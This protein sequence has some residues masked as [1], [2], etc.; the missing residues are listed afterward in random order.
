MAINWKEG[1][2]GMNRED[3]CRRKENRISAIRRFLLF[4]LL[5]LVLSPGILL[6]DET[7]E[8]F[9]YGEPT[10]ELTQQENEW[11]RQHPVITLSV[12]DGYPPRNFL[13]PKGQLVG[14]SI[15]YIDLLAK[16]LGISIRYE[17]SPWHEALD[18]ALRHEVHGVIN[19]DML[20]DRKPYLDF[21]D[22]Y[23]VYPQALV[24]REDAAPCKS[25]DEFSGKKVAVA[26]GSSALALI[27]NN[28]P[29]VE[30]LEVNNAW[31]GIQLV[32]EG[33]AD[34]AFD[35]LA[36]LNYFI[37]MSCP[38]D[39][40][41]ALVSYEEPVGYSR[42]GLRNDRP[43][44]LSVFN[45]A[46]ASLSP[47]DHQEIQ[48]RW[49]G[50]RVPLVA[51]LDPDLA[52]SEEERTWVKEHPVVR[53]YSDPRW[54]PIEFFDEKGEL[55]GIVADFLKTVRQRTGIQFKT[56]KNLGWLEALEQVGQK[57][58]DMFSCISKT[59]SRSQFLDFTC[60][61][62]KVPVAIYTLDNIPY[63]NYLEQLNG[64]KVIV[65]RD[66]YIQE[67]LQQNHP[68]ID[69]VLI[70]E[71]QAAFD[72]LNGRE[73][74]A[75]I[76]ATLPCS[77]Y[78]TKLG[79]TNIKING[80]TPFYYNPSMGVR[81]DWPIFTGSLQKALDSINETERDAIRQKWI[82]IKY[83]HA[84]DYTLLWKIV[85]F[86]LLALSL[87]SFWN[88]RL[89]H[90]I[91][92]RKRAESALQKAH[93]E[94][95]ARVEE[96]TAEIVKANREL[97]DEIEERKLAE[98]ALRESEEK[99]RLLVEYANDAIFVVQDE[100]ILFPNPKAVGLFGCSAEE[101]ACTSFTNF[102]HPQD[103]TFVLDRYRKG[104]SGEGF[105]GAY[106]F[107]ISNQNGQV[108]SVQ[109]SAVLI[110]W[111]GKPA[112]LSFLRDV[113]EQR[114]LETQLRQAQ[115]MEAIGTL[116][117]G[118]AHDFNNILTSIIGFAEILFLFKIEKN[119]PE[120]HDLEQILKAAHR[121]KDLV[122][123]ILT[124]GRRT[125]Q[126]MKPI[127]LEPIIT[128]AVRFLKAVLPTTI[129]IR[130]FVRCKAARI[131]AD[132]TQM[133]QVVMN[134]CTNAAHAMREKGGV[135]EIELQ[136]VELDSA[137][138]EKFLY[139]APGPYVRLTLTDTGHGMAG[140]VMERIFDP[141]FTT[142]EQG[143]G[144]GLGL[145]VVH[146]IVK[147][148]GG[149]IT[150]ESEV[151]KGSTFDVL[152][153]R[154]IGEA[155]TSAGEV[156]DFISG[157]NERILFI[158]DEESIVEMAKSA[159]ENL[160]YEVIGVTNSIE[161]LETFQ[162]QPDRN[163]LVI[164]DLTMPH[165]TGLELAEK[166]MLVKPDIPIILFSGFGEESIQQDAQTKG[167]REFL[168]KPI[169][170]LALTKTIRKVLDQGQIE[171]VRLT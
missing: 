57:K 42:I 141:Y 151:G 70:E 88:R 100:S 158:D 63:I 26:K 119:R 17:G 12:D 92:E 54:M 15:D 103:R 21:T 106:S 43:E 152:L 107:R 93:D 163:H 150:V 165:M 5:S 29:A 68:K 72:L 104:L 162:S 16:R 2:P 166:L 18:K 133:L 75:F 118:I 58:I 126:E 125:E 71:F 108:L 102:I 124:F 140:E 160:G 161:A 24:T 20:Q 139:L 148:H 79:F 38:S 36:V 168:S 37:S 113:T 101:L 120:R 64:K 153:P 128:E 23:A 40:K 89:S 34:G 19:A 137:A 129:E 94:L 121:A 39:L 47:Q 167:I 87:L 110:T 131:L 49:F 149:S 116:A 3:M 136:E 7:P 142:K 130:R 134:L 81:N 91:H 82:T 154:L 90:E 44:L 84:F 96:R 51:A 171:S 143:E 157:G 156:K 4:V 111:E 85:V 27:K 170:L 115:K 48:D 69:L 77:H 67:T 14:I 13:N 97:E 35:D 22:V 46:I 145:A 50:V 11:L 135:L 25:L 56:P 112:A 53:V 86:G 78:L 61:Y 74:F 123:Q 76:E 10:I 65:R 62:L 114:E 9:L 122:Q 80:T 169:T 31:E 138:V 147:S 30:I 144:T 28:H 127:L 164:T 98:K 59:P 159:L 83:E 105:P 8:G 132:P 32:I 117:G 55:R 41:F 155:T 60:P 99:Y 6:S 1:I 52:L 95:E 33:K 45:K 66:S 73:A 146:G 109:L